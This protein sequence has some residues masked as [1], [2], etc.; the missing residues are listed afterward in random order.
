MLVVVTMND[1]MNKKGHVCVCGGAN[2]GA[3]ASKMVQ[4][5]SIYQL[6]PILRGPPALFQADKVRQ[7]HTGAPRMAFARI[8]ESSCPLPTTGG[9]HLS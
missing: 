1:R 5:R 2:P 6:P 3:G 9:G 8:S 4:L 7:A